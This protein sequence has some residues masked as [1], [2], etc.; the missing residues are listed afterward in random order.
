M[1][2]G[3]AGLAEAGWSGEGVA[4]ATVADQLGRLSTEL[5]WQEQS[6]S[7]ARSLTL[8]VATAGDADPEEVERRLATL[9]AHQPARTIVLREHLEDR[10]DAEVRM[11]CTV[12][13]APGVV[14]LCHDR[15]ELRA[16]RERLMHADSLVRPLLV[17]GVPV[18]VWLP[19]GDLGP[20]DAPL[21]ALA[22]HLVLDTALGRAASSLRR[23]AV[24]AGA[25]RVH[26]LVWGALA[27]WRARVA[28]A[29]EDPVARG[30]L[31]R[32]AV[33]EVEHA[34][35]GEA[36]ALLLAGWIAARAGW[37]LAAGP[38]GRHRFGSPIGIV[39]REAAAP[40]G[41]HGGVER[42]AL[43]DA[44]GEG[45]DLRRGATS[46]RGRDVFVE[47]LRP[48]SR[49]ARGYAEALSALAPVVAGAA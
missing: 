45:V 47:A 21:A 15:V 31:D 13:P 25:A 33:L 17:A 23:A 24:A 32:A 18:A 40:G 2:A 37:P 28:A 19:D 42:L 39:V 3:T 6:R 16:D 11:A 30:L 27:W 44:A 41:G 43:R 22:D 1:S 46:E 49:Y 5:F 38:E 8:V 48:S 34:P 26:D 10:V 14:G 29:F 35:G 36:A 12:S 4:L 9:A 7:A 20:C